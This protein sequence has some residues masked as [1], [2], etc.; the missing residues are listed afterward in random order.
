MR[1]ETDLLDTHTLLGG[2]IDVSVGVSVGTV[3]NG[4]EVLELRVRVGLDGLGSLDPVGGADF[5][6]SVLMH[7]KVNDR[8]MEANNVQ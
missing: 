8:D 2:A 4:G 7:C 1:L 5:T 6:M 3:S